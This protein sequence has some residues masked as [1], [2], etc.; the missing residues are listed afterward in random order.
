VGNRKATLFEAV[1]RLDEIIDIVSTNSAGC[2]ST[3]LVLVRLLRLRRI[4]EGEVKRP[5]PSWT[6]VAIL[7]REAARILGDL[8][9]STIRWLLRPL[10]WGNRGIGVW[11]SGSL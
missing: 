4:L 6:L 8:L 10:V 1:K 11:D 3:R 2:G 5:Q 9:I 7:V